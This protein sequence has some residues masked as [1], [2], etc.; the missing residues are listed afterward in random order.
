MAS[1]Y[2]LAR[3]MAALL[4]QLP[5]DFVQAF[6]AMPDPIVA[7]RKFQRFAGLDPKSEEARAFVAL[8]DW[9]ND[10]VPV[11][12]PVADNALLGWYGA[13]TPHRGLWKPAGT[14]IDPTRLAMPTLIVIPGAD[15]IVPPPSASAV[16]EKI[17]HGERLDLP[18]GHIGM[19][20]GR[21]AEEALWRPL[22][23]WIT[24]V[25]R[26]A[27]GDSSRG[28]RLPRTRPRT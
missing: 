17:H 4:G 7:L 25:G 19:V 20:V 8:E 21:R 18:L 23:G 13:N 1:F 10:G 26:V 16:L 6:F 22:A 9:L 11:T 28:R 24:R 14:A 12:L 2:R 5:V 3:P 15:R 27:L